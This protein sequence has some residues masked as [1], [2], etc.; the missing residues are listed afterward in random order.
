MNSIR[1]VLFDAVGTVIV[2]EPPVARAYWLAAQQFGSQ[3]DEPTIAERFRVAFAAEEEAD[4]LLHRGRATEQREQL[5][6]RRIV[7]HVFDEVANR[8]GLFDALW[9]HFGQSDSWRVVPGAVE[10]WQALAARGLLVGV[11]SNF[12]RRLEALWAGLSPLVSTPHV[13]ASSRLGWRKPSV[14]FFRA[15]EQLLAL[16]A[17]RIML[18]GDDLVNDYRAARAAGWRAVLVGNGDESAVD[19]ERIATLDEL[20]RLLEPD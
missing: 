1:A 16:P 17:E 15:I 3:L 8:R 19:I 14:E 13:F 5:R 12:D 10:G 6:W 2:P 9:R 7:A 4:A 11:A 18:V 20:P